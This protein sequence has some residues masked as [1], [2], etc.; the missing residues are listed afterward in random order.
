MTRRPT[1]WVLMTVA[2][3]AL[4]AAFGISYAL[5]LF[6]PEAEPVSIYEDCSSCD[7]KHA[8]KDRLREALKNATT[9]PD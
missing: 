2:V 6:E 1:L 8:G 4:F 9:L 5:D 3:V 7:A